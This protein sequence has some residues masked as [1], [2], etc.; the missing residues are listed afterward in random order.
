MAEVGTG[1]SGSCRR[2][3][4]A[5]GSRRPRR[6]RGWRTGR[7]RRTIRLDPSRGGDAAMRHGEK[8]APVAAAVTALS[9]LLCCLPVGFA[10]AVATASVA[11]FVSSYQ[12][13]FI[14]LSLL[15]LGLGL[16]QLPPTAASVR[17]AAEI[18]RYRVR[19]LG[20]GR[21][22][23]SLVPPDACIAP[24]RLGALADDETQPRPDFSAR[25]DCPGVRLV[26]AR[27]TA[28]PGGSAS[29]HDGAAGIDRRAPRRLQPARRQ[30]PHHRP[31]VADLNDVSAGGFRIRIRSPAAVQHRGSRVCGVGA[32]AHDRPGRA[33]HGRV[34]AAG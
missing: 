14:A 10:A 29:T 27:G 3:S 4:A 1:W 13:W 5:V 11:S 22:A 20:G 24:R 31:A 18:V 23:G 9:T 25:R 7:V 16:L 6:A 21:D 34:A 2:E 15:L 19:R 33:G 30:G 26:S 17:D 28:H 12:R 8:F 32:D